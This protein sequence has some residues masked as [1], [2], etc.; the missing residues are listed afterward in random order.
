[1]HTLDTDTRIDRTPTRISSD[2][3][4]EKLRRNLGLGF[5]IVPGAENTCHIQL[6]LAQGS[7][8]KPVQL[9]RIL[10][11]WLV[12]NLGCNAAAIIVDG[13]HKHL[14]FGRAQSGGVVLGGGFFNSTVRRINATMALD[15]VGNSFLYEGGEGILYPAIV[16]ATE[17]IIRPRR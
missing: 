16:L 8:T 3:V 11:R 14:A 5:E 2:I 4:I 10:L 6:R 15:Q 12:P 7:L 1:M 9:G 13:T 17:N